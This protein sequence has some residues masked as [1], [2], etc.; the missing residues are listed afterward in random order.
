MTNPVP[1][2]MS[3]RSLVAPSP[4]LAV[5]GRAR[6]VFAAAALVFLGAVEGQAASPGL[7]VQSATARSSAA[8]GPR[9]ALLVVPQPASAGGRAATAHADEEAY[10]KRLRDIGFDVWTFGPADRPQLERGLREAAGRLPEEAQVA[11]FV[12]GPTVGGVDDIHL[13]P[14]D[15]PSDIG[16]RPT[17]LDSEGVRLSDVMRRIAQRRPRDLVAVIDECQAASGAR[18]DFDAAAGNS[19]A[20]LIG[21]ERA[22]RRTASPA[23]LAGRASLRDPMLTAM[24]QEGETFLQ[25]YETLKRGLAGSDLEPRASGALTTSFAFIPQGFFGGLR[26]DCNKIDPNAEPVSLRG[27][28]LEPAIKAC[29]AG[30]ATYPFARPFQDRLQAGREQRAYQRA[31]A[32]CDDPTSTASYTTAYPAGRFRSLVETFALE[33]GRNRDRQDEARRQQEDEARR[34]QEDARRRQEEM[35]RQ[36]AEARRQREADEQ[37]QADEAR[38]QR[39]LQQRTTVGSASGWTLTYSTD[40]LDIS[41]LANDQY[42]PQKQTYTTIWHSRQHGEQVVMYVQVSPNERCGSAQQFIAEQIRPRRNQISRAQEVTSSPVRTGYVLEGRGTAV[43]QGTFDDRSFYDFATIRRDDRS[44]IVNVG[45]RFPAEF[46]DMYRAELLR[47][48]NSM[49]LPGRDIFNN[50][51]G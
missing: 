37:R 34:R 29:E 31:V 35:D 26:S 51:C 5:M 15:A 44:T 43:S 6:R 42:D 47:M 18:C 8:T 27:V 25:S 11:V 40:L 7:A 12:L 1:A 28:N 24:A 17:M 46:S 20:S 30:T 50:R 16:Q 13:I 45:G 41:R 49:Q 22:P 48:M 9:I 33:C 32:S 2:P 21:S 3:A 10:R 19:G 23:P 36:W 14:Q 39:E 38:R 4:S